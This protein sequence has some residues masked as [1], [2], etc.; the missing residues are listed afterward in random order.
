MAREHLL[1]RLLLIRLH[2]ESKLV[3]GVAGRSKGRAWPEESLSQGRAWPEPPP[4]PHPAN[5][6]GPQRPFSISS[7]PLNY[8]RTTGSSVI[9]L[10]ISQTHPPA[11]QQY[12][13]WAGKAL[14]S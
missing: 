11:Y 4:A 6:G 8:A 9:H 10:V 3:P 1:R 13:C 14:G 12:L 7:L 2:L 5:A